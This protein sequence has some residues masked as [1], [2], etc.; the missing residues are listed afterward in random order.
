MIQKLAAQDRIKFVININLFL[1]L[2]NEK[3][4]NAEKNIL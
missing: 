2:I 4:F 1:N 3:I